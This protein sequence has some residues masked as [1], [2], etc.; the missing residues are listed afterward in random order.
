MGK[1]VLYYKRDLF[2]KTKGPLD[3]RQENGPVAPWPAPRRRARGGHRQGPTFGSWP[4]S[5]TKMIKNK[6][7][8][9]KKVPTHI[10]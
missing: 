6:F 3:R 5:W 10:K 8:I 9:L 4:I 7:S 2:K 1:Q